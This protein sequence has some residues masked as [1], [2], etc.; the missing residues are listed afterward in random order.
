M[1]LKVKKNGE[2]ISIL[3]MTYL[4]KILGYWDLVELEKKIA[5]YAKAFGMRVKVFDK[6]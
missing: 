1:M 2:E 5:K 3:V 4:I 6:K